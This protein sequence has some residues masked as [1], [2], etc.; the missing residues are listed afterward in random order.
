[1]YNLMVC[2]CLSVWRRSNK[3]TAMKNLIPEGIESGVINCCGIVDG[4]RDSMQDH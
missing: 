2:Y 1:M 4:V 3:I